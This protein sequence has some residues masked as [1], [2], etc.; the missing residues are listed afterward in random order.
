[1]TNGD[2]FFKIYVGAAAARSNPSGGRVK[3]LKRR[4]KEHL[5]YAN[6]ETRKAES[7]QLHCNEIRKEGSR[8]N[9]VVLV[10][11]AEP[12]DRSLVHIAEAVMTILFASWN[13]RCFAVLRPNNLPQS[14]CWGLNNANPLDFGVSS[15]VD[16]GLHRVRQENGQNLA[17]KRREANIA[18]ASEGGVFR[19][20]AQQMSPS[21]WDFKFKIC[22]ETIKIPSGIGVY[23][24]IHHWRFVEVHCDVDVPHNS[25]YAMRARRGDTERR[26]GI[27]LQGYQANGKYEDAKFVKWIQC[28]S[29]EAVDR[30]RR[31][32][33]QLNR[34][35]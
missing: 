9:F 35:Y 31:I 4:I 33:A 10:R 1:M 16:P 3:G 11:F 32:M 2:S 12:V 7:G 17:R 18:K 26:L 23:M 13:S 28:D 24:G 5:S 14:P 22:G 8:C 21:Y 27:Y 20:T 29:A 34:N 30:A 15:C 6:S 25:A 19:V